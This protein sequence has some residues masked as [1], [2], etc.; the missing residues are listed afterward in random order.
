MAEAREA[1]SY[2]DQDGSGKISAEEFF[3][4][5]RAQGKTPNMAEIQGLIEAHDANWDW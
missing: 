3:N 4:I 1:F 2:Y 5:V